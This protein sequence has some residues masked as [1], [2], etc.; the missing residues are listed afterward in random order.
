[1]TQHINRRRIRANIVQEDLAEYVVLLK[2]LYKETVGALLES[3][4]MGVN[5]SIEG[6]S[7]GTDAQLIDSASASGN[8]KTGYGRWN[9]ALPI[10]YVSGGTI[11][12][13]IRAK[14]NV[15]ANVTNILDLICHKNDNDGLVGSDICATGPFDPITTS[16]ANY[17]FTITP[18]GLVAGDTFDLRAMSTQND[19]GASSGSKTYVSKISMLLDIKG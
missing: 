7:M 8:S 15:L 16:F 17:D 5:W 10:E 14:T 4:P 13:R 2:T 12:C 1:M 19:A 3:G 11:I 18:T 6:G 9:F